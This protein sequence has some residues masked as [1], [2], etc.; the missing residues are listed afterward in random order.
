MKICILKKSTG[1]DMF[2]PNEG[3]IVLVPEFAPD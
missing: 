1:A 3:Y 2:G